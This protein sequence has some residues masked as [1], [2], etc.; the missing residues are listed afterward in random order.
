ME[1]EESK[2]NFDWEEIMILSFLSE[3]Y[4]LLKNSLNLKTLMYIT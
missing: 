4:M 2:D 3:G 1:R